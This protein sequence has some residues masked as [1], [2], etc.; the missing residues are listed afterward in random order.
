MP[1]KDL[2]EQGTFREDLYYR[3][4][5]CKIDVPA[6]RERKEDVLFLEHPKKL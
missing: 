5:I 3:L 1:L 4:N 2:V 6:L